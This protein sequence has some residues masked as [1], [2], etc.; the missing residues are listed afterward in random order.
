MLE[1]I[2]LKLALGAAVVGACAMAGRALA[3]VDTRR[4]GMLAEM[5]DGLQLLRV[6]MLD[7]LMPLDMAL[8]RSQAYVLRE[9][10]GS[11]N[12]GTAYDAWQDVSRRET[13]RGGKLDS[14]SADDCEVLDRFFRRL[15]DSSIEEQRQLFDAA[16]REIGSLESISR[17]ESAQKNRLFTALGALAGAAVV[18]GLV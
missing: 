4:S 9:V 8:A 2:T 13:A 18:V 15:G 16:I 14:L 1:D 12:G 17:T 6:Y 7:E 5:M 3:K 11:M 10:G